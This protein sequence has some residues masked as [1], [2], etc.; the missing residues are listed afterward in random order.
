MIIILL[1]VLRIY[2]RLLAMTAAVA[3]EAAAGQKVKELASL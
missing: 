1:T 2:R 3:T